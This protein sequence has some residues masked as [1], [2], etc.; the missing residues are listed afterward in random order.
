MK[1]PVSAI[2]ASG[3]RLPSGWYYAADSTEVAAGQVVR[4][5][6]FGQALALWRTERGDLNVSDATCPHMGSDLTR[7]GKV[8]GEHLQ[9]FA[10]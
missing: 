2:H 6:L 3:P 8:K 4:K 9:C 10:H 7:L 5:E 1:Y